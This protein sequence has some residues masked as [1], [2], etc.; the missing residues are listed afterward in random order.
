[1]EL[2]NL[3]KLMTFFYGQ[4]RLCEPQDEVFQTWLAGIENVYRTWIPCP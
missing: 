4:T 1:M 2:T 3:Q